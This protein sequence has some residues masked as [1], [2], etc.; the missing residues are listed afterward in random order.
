MIRMVSEDVR[1]RW[2]AAPREAQILCFNAIYH[3]GDSPELLWILSDEPVHVKAVVKLDG[4]GKKQVS[5]EGLSPAVCTES[6]VFI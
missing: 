4:R 6:Y 3:P 1:Q 2:L 5:H